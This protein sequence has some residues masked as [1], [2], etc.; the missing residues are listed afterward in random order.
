MCSSY[1]K[2]PG[3]GSPVTISRLAFYD[4]K[5]TDFHPQ[6]EGVKGLN[7]RLG[8]KKRGA[9]VCMFSRETQ[10]HGRL[11]PTTRLIGMALL[12]RVAEFGQENPTDATTLCCKESVLQYKWVCSCPFVFGGIHEYFSMF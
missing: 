2:L 4:V 12:L 10:L 9:G 11:L 7:E 5:E 8:V 6:K 1:L 3:V